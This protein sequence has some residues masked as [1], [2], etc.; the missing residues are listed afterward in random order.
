M[1]QDSRVHSGLSLNATSYIEKFPIAIHYLNI[2]MLP[3]RPSSIFD[4][5]STTGAQNQAPPF[6]QM[7]VTKRRKRSAATS[8]SSQFAESDQCI[9]PKTNPNLNIFQQE[10]KRQKSV[11]KLWL[12]HQWL[13]VGEFCTINAIFEYKEAWT[14]AGNVQIFVTDII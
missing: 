1:Q 14:R 5:Q 6:I 2:M 3:F 12:N 7:Y 9:F 10:S 13:T 8:I 11:G 4:I